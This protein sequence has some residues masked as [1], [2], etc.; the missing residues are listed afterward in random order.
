[1]AH[2]R[3]TVRTALAHTAWDFDTSIRMVADGRLDLAPLA[4][5]TVT[6]EGLADAFATLADGTSGAV[7]V[8]VDPQP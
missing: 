6:L 1:M 3:S 4:Q 8:L 2:P 7:K 5:R